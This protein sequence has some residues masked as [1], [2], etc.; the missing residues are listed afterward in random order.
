MNELL[1]MDD[2]ELQEHITQII[3]AENQPV[4]DVINALQ[5]ADNRGMETMGEVL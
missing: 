5:E 1:T 4:E 3:K 2:Q